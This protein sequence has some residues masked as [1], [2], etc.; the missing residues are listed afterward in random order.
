MNQ[1]GVLL[2]VASL[3]RLR[4]LH[5]VLIHK[6]GSETILA[7]LDQ[8]LVHAVRSRRL[9]RQSHSSVLLMWGLKCLPLLMPYLKCFKLQD[10]PWQ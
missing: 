5:S 4:T 8:V 1:I 2:I 10:R 7:E 9:F 6:I 3:R